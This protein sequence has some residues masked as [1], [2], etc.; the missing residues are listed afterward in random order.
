[1]NEREVGKYPIKE[2]VHIG[3]ILRRERPIRF[4]RPKNNKVDGISLTTFSMF[5]EGNG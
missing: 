3:V 1:M 2:K 5:F 4:F